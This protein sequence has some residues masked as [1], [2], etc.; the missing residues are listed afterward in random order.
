MGGGDKVVRHETGVTMLARRTLLAVI[1]LSLALVSGASLAQDKY[2]SRPIR[3][4]VPYP[5]GS[6]TNDILGRALASRLGVE[7]GQQVVVDNRSGASG[8]MGSE[9]AAKSTPDGY[10]LLIGVEIGRAHV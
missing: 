1:A 10:T 9:L 3:V 7:L 4:I 8:N 6:S 5:P 2:P